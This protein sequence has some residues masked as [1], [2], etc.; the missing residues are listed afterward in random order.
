VKVLSA[1]KLQL[2]SFAISAVSVARTHIV[3]VRKSHRWL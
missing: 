1:V 2:L 3:K